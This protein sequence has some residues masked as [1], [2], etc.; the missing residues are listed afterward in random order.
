MKYFTNIRYFRAWKI[1]KALKELSAEY[2]KRIRVEQE[3]IQFNLEDDANRKKR[4]L[5]GKVFPR[6]KADF[7]ML[8]AMVDRW[9]KAEI[10]RICNSYSGPAKIT[11]FYILLD[12]EVQML[13]AIENHRQQIK[14]DIKVQKDREFFRIIGD[15]I[16]WNNRYKDWTD[17]YKD[18]YIEM[19]TLETQQGHE[20]YKIFLSI[21]D[22][23]VDLEDRLQALL[24]IKLLLHDHNCQLSNEL[25]SLIDRACELMVRGL[26]NKQLDVLMKRIQGLLLK[27][28]KTP[29]CS[30]G[31]TNRLLRVK[32]KLMQNDLFYCNRCQKLKSH[33][34]FAIHSGVD[35][36]KVCITCSWDDRVME[37]WFD[38]APYRFMLR[39]IR[40]EERTKQ[41]PSSV[42]F[43]LQDKDIHH[44]VIN[45]WHGH[46]AI[47]ENNDVY[48][49]RLCRWFRNLPWAPWN[50]VL[51]TLEESLAHSKIDKLEEVYDKHFFCRVFNKHELAKRHFRA[52][53]KLEEYFQ[54][55]GEYDTKWNEIRKFVDF[56]AVSSKTKVFLSCH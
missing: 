25:V 3:M 52:V 6:T 42:A 49:L 23:N 56:V 2:K 11:A 19:D 27:H 46:S 53:L 12:K 29:E 14:K 7:C 13:R 5:I 40:R 44:I 21:S 55:F 17:Q 41:S 30:F 43:I 32:E 18:L 47:S 51:L 36:L 31:V 15:P 34:H 33:A 22:E 9:K 24:N 28:I 50:C 39:L 8:F 45:I 35:K 26:T 20:Y 4:E 10:K 38:L 1:R 48:N 16:A 54:E 37:P